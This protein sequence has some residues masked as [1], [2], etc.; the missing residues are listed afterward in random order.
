MEDV[1]NPVPI[2]EIYF[3]IIKARNSKKFTHNRVTGPFF[4]CE[5]IN[6]TGVLPQHDRA[7]RVPL[8]E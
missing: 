8:L 7:V 5:E 4:F 1:H 2:F 6:H 3:M